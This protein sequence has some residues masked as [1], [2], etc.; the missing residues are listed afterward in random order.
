LFN[1]IIPGLLQEGI[2][3]EEVQQIISFNPAGMLSQF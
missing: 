2:S 1:S 3:K